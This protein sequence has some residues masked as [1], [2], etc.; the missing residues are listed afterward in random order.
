MSEIERPS[1]TPIAAAATPDEEEDPF[2]APM[3]PVE[4]FE[5]WKSLIDTPLLERSSTARSAFAKPPCAQPPRIWG[6][7]AIGLAVFGLISAWASGVF[8]VKTRD[9]VIVLHDLPDNA[10]VLV[11]GDKVSVRSPKREALP[12]L[13]FHPA[14]AACK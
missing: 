2:F 14:S 1:A 9:G 10:E 4:P 7:V 3:D 11:D 5:R 13:W 12:R 6:S 8:S